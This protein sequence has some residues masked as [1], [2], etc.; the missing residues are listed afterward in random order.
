[1]TFRTRFAPSP[2]GPLH[3]GHA[4]SAI[5]AHDM[6][7][8]EGGVFLLRIDD[9]DRTRARPEWEEAI[10]EDLTWLGL[11]WD[12]AP[13][14]QS[15][16]LSDYRAALDRLAARGLTYPCSCRRRDIEAAASAPQEG[17][18]THGPDGRIYPGTCRGRPMSDLRPGDALRLDVAKAFPALDATFTE[19][20]PA[21]A[22][23][24]RVTT[25]HLLTRVGD[26]V[27][28][29][30]QMGASYHLSV[31]IDDAAQGITHAVRGEDLFEAS[32]LH[33]A[34]HHLLG[35]RVPVSHHHRLI[36]DDTGKR[37]AKRD[38]ARAIRTYRAEGAT[39]ADIR[40]MVGL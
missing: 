32:A 2:S 26:P 19:T 12:E 37:L 3:L 20:G 9:I 38:D 22:G 34:L 25:D 13:Y 14:R 36:R 5:T 11:A 28:A 23:R 17:T 33:T 39:P 27:L 40:A 4:F 24:H 16:H 15:D 35:T 30:P 29:R 10:L 6:A 31:V 7:R 1:M 21:H 8:A 18:P